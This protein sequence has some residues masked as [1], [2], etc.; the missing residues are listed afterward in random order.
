MGVP[1]PNKTQDT[2]KHFLLF[3]IA[4]KT[5]GTA[6]AQPTLTANGNGPQAGQAYTRFFHMYEAPGPS[7]AN[8]TWD[9]SMLEGM[10]EEEVTLFSPGDLP[11]GG[12][13]PEATV[14]Q[15][16][17]FSNRFIRLQND[18]LLLVGRGY[19]DLVVPYDDHK[20]EM[21]FPCTFGTEW[22]DEYG[23]TYLENG[24]LWEVAGMILGVADGHGTLEMPYG[25]VGNVL[26]VHTVEVEVETEGEVEFTAITEL[27]CYHVPGTPWPLVRLVRITLWL[28]EEPI[29]FEFTEWAYPAVTSVPEASRGPMTL[30]AWPN[31]AHDHVRVTLPEG[32]GLLLELCDGAGRVVRREAGLAGGREHVLDLTGLEGGTYIATTTSQGGERGTV[33]IMVL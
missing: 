6:A 20:L 13:F 31:P 10:E 14:A 19:D 27:F 30:H 2:M 23:G 28:G 29:E 7:G 33:R 8:V 17:L 16:D 1:D 18:A 25:T 3:L 9:F 15:A 4:A 5:I 32:E 24:V 12:S 11:N 22:E 21:P 26:R